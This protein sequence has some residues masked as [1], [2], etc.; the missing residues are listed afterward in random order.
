MQ[1]FWAPTFWGQP[2]SLSSGEEVVVSEFVAALGDGSATG[3]ATTLN[4]KRGMKRREGR[5]RYI[6]K[7]FVKTMIGFVV[8][9]CWV[10][11]RMISICGLSEKLGI[12]GSSD[13]T[14][15]ADSGSS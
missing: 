4:I 14:E 10:T 11:I 8:L 13:R 2:R 1:M 9:I 12:C 7:T 15:E 3:M 5:W 6:A